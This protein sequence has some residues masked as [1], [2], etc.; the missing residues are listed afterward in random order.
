MKIGETRNNIFLKPTTNIPQM[1]TPCLFSGKVEG[2]PASKV[3]VSGC[4][5]SSETL[6]SIVS[7]QLPGGILDLSLVHGITRNV[8]TQVDQRGR[9]ESLDYETV[10]HTLSPGPLQTQDYAAYFSGPLPSRV[11]LRTHIRYDNTLLKHFHHSH[12]KTKDWINKIVGLTQTRMFHPSMKM[13][14]K[15]K[16]KSV[17]HIA[18]SIKADLASAK[19]IEKKRVPQFTSYFCKDF[20]ND[21]RRGIG[22][23]AAAC[24]RDGKAFSIVESW[25]TDVLTA[26][27]F[28]H[29][30]GHIIGM[31]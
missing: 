21:Y 17:G 25:N 18:E 14:V 4:Y 7:S 8:T 28:A 9:T 3:F 19:N 15:I 16:V 10:N 11:V 24:H 27:G 30:L 22:Y 29:E 13:K 26:K 1:E 12:Q 23:V 20:A 5:N 31:V 2:D 6:A